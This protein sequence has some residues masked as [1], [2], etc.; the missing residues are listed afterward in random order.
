M[1]VYRLKAGEVG[2]LM[3]VRDYTSY[4]KARLDFEFALAIHRLIGSDC[5]VVYLSIE[6]VSDND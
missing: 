5:S 1:I 2:N 4:R 3:I 6:E